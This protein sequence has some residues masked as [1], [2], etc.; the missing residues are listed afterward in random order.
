VLVCFLALVLPFTARIE[1]TGY[2]NAMVPWV[3]TALLLAVI[4][5]VEPIVMNTLSRGVEKGSLLERHENEVDVWDK[6]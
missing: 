5:Y 1:K 3:V 4:L 6:L 2:F